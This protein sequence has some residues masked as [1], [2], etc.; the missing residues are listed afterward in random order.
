[1]KLDG[2][3]LLI[4]SVN[5]SRFA[6]F[7]AKIHIN[8]IRI[9]EIFECTH[10]VRDE[11]VSHIGDD[12]R[13]LT[14]VVGSPLINPRTLCFKFPNRDERNTVLQGLRAMISDAHLNSS[15]T[16][17]KNITSLSS[18]SSSPVNDELVASLLSPAMNTGS[19]SANAT[20]SGLPP[21]QKRMSIH[22]TPSSMVN[23]MFANREKQSQ[24]QSPAEEVS[25]ENT[26]SNTTAAAA[27]AA[28]ANST[29]LLNAKKEF[30]AIK[31][32]KINKVLIYQ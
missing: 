8:P 16:A 26:N 18:P 23:P 13:F 25:H 12:P 20:P 4:F 11:I 30:N 10:G 1:M 28:A 21:V 29:G 6:I 22:D 2:T 31:S 27:A 14:I 9:D 32:A 24:S 19:A 5:Y 3:N 7:A 17:I 15:S